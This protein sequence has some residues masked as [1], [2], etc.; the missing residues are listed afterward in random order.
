[1]DCERDHGIASLQVPWEELD[2][3]QREPW[4]HRCAA[5]AYERGL[6]DGLRRAARRLRL[7]QMTRPAEQLETEANTITPEGQSS[8]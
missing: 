5:C 1:M 7:E 2:K 4:R 3:S 6:A 8:I